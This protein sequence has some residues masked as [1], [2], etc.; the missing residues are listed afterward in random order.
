MQKTKT[1]KKQ[2]LTRSARRIRRGTVV[3]VAAVASVVLGAPSAVPAPGPAVEGESVRVLSWNIYHG[4]RNDELGGEKNFP[5][6]LDQLADIAPD[7]F[8]SIETYGSAKE[9]QDALTDR[10]GKGVY[11]AVQVTDGSSDNL[12]IFTRYD[13]V[14]TFPKPTGS[15]VSDF[16]IGG[17]RV[18]L[19]S[20]RQLN[21]FDTWTSYTNP[22]IGDM[23]DTNAKDVQAG[24]KPT[25][26]PQRVARAEKGQQIPQVT[27]I[28][29]QQVPYMLDGN[30][31]PVLL[32]GDLNTVPAADWSAKWA[33]CAHHF[34]LSYDLAATDVLTDA[35]FQDTYR[36]A[37]PDVCAD[38]GRTWSPHPDYANMITKD[39]I[40]FIFARGSGIEVNDA[41][42]VDERLPQH[43][44]GAF[45][46]DHGA[47]IADLTVS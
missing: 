13:V 25:Y 30:T 47:V 41:Y 14:K 4:G 42:V 45:Y 43:E 28:V 33:D 3:L 8:F 23:I 39:R 24:R 21:L 46:S 34:G 22:W 18:Q 26:H 6:V 1:L 7:V 29:H 19:P 11:Q 36:A 12:W 2:A 40:D 35:G 9:I 38:P 27:D 5:L 15:T 37:N 10:V 16:N 32:A 44:S 31:D 17:A 20:G